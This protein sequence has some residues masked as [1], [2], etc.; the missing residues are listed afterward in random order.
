MKTE[1]IGSE[2]V[3]QF[4]DGRYSLLQWLGG[5]VQSGVFLTEL[6]G[7]QAQ[8]A[9]IRLVLADS[10]DAD[11]Q[12]AQWASASTLSHPHLM[13]LFHTGRCQIGTDR[14]VYAV[15]EYAEEN[16]SQILPVRALTAQETREML[17][18]VLAA[19]AYLH[20]KGFVH[21]DLKPSNILVV[22]DQVKLSCEQVQ[23]VGRLGRRLWAPAAYEAPECAAETISPAA[24]M[25]SLG[26][27][28]VEA[29]TQHPPVWERSKQ[30]DPIVAEPVPEPFASIARECLRIDP[31][32]RCTTGDVRAR[33]DGNGSIAKPDDGEGSIGA[34][35]TK[36]RLP[37]I[38][39]A[40]LA[41]IA[42]VVI[43]LMRPHRTEPTP[44]VTVEQLSLPAIAASPQAPPAASKPHASNGP[45]VKGEVAEQAMP[46]VAAKA[47]A[48]IQGQVNV[49]VRVAV[50]PAGEVSSAELD[51]AGPSKYFAKAALEAA[52]RWR[53]KP[54]EIKGEAVSSV[55][56]LQFKF[57]RS[58]TEVNPIKVS[59]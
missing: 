11:A 18:P 9:A 4:I 45:A 17:D 10:S 24:D 14:L 52:R 3:G 33:L 19:L 13:R 12:I 27:T 36:L 32:R 30:K 26:V 53:F 40:V 56:L 25:W 43:L 58:G 1:T 23:T 2:W 8:R 59:P 46:D 47:V 57:K 50:D 41:V 7:A 22:N 16:L 51:S 31:A 42:F 54:I 49:R 44:A 39:A 29:L 5:S 15:T 6:P 55:W 28:L 35:Q 21:G 48:S 37:I 38:V 20:G 34:S